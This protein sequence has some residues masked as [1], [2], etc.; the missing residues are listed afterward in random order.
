MQMGSV[1]RRHDQSTTAEAGFG[2]LV[3][4]GNKAGAMKQAKGGGQFSLRTEIPMILAMY[5]V[6]SVPILSF[7]L[8][9][10]TRELSAFV[11]HSNLLV[12]SIHNILI[13]KKKALQSYDLICVA[14]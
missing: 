2:S 4:A 6:Y 11:F 10:S 13:T 8:S 14:D 7:I 5:I 1:K 12:L 9:Y 3:A